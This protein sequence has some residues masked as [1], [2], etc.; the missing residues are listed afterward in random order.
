MD[1]YFTNNLKMELVDDMKSK[2]YD[3]PQ[4][5][6]TPNENTQQTYFIRELIRKFSNI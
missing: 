3:L 2:Q 5:S 6:G 4:T 1:N